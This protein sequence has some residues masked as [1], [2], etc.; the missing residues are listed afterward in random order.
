MGI[1]KWISDA[2][3]T[4]S[5]SARLKDAGK[6]YYWVSEKHRKKCNK[7]IQK[8]HRDGNVLVLPWDQWNRCMQQPKRPFDSYKVV[9]DLKFIVEFIKGLVNPSSIREGREIKELPPKKTISRREIEEEKEKEKKEK[10]KAREKIPR[11]R[12]PRKKIP[13]E[14]IPREKIERK[15]IE[16]RKSA[17]N[18]NIFGKNLKLMKFIKPELLR[19]FEN[20]DKKTI[21][22]I[23]EIELDLIPPSRKSYAFLYTDV[24]RFN[25]GL[26]NTDVFS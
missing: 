26:F 14:K 9:R 23:A 22:E 3:V 11:E 4:A 12:I 17:K 6:K 8:A 21:V 10:K 25:E 19:R 5:V 24:C 2:V 13:K 15:K 16:A 1:F 20:L 18:F 7:I